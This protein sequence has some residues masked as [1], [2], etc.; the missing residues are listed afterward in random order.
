MTMSYELNHNVGG[1]NLHYITGTHYAAGH[2]SDYT[3]II[4]SST[5][6]QANKTNI[7]SLNVDQRP[8]T[9]RQYSNRKPYDNNARSLMQLQKKD[10]E[11]PITKSCNKGEQPIKFDCWCKNTEV[12]STTLVSSLSPSLLL[13][14]E[15]S[16]Y[17][18]N[19]FS[20]SSSTCDMCCRVLTLDD[21]QLYKTSDYHNLENVVFKKRQPLCDI[22]TN[23]IVGSFTLLILW[24]CCRHWRYNTTRRYVRNKKNPL[25]NIVNRNS[26]NSIRGFQCFT[27]FLSQMRFHSRH[28]K[29]CRHII[30][31]LYNINMKKKG[32]LR[33]VSKE[34]L[35]Q[36]LKSAHIILTISVL[37]MAQEVCRT[38]AS[39]ADLSA[40]TNI[41]NE[42]IGQ[43][44][45]KIHNRSD[46]HV[47]T[48]NHDRN[49]TNYK[50]NLTNN[51][52][53]GKKSDHLIKSG[54]DNSQ[55]KHS[56]SSVLVG[57]DV[58]ISDDDDNSYDGLK[59]VATK[60]KFTS[61]TG[62]SSV[63]NH[64]NNNAYLDRMDNLE[65]SLEA[66]LIK[67]AYGT[68]STTKR[69]IPDNSQ[70][71]SLTTIVTPLLT[72]LR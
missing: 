44:I 30:T 22:F 31:K 49:I 11:L 59:N 5:Y 28:R 53:N 13:Y 39:L 65:R 21:G 7:N 46:G 3:T 62:D 16:N 33:F 12:L 40:V 56:P 57:T 4:T 55:L 26:E 42:N 15:N 50:D 36:N 63:N 25:I 41:P 32:T 70:V 61:S 27:A 20:S 35:V 43:I 18:D 37:L 23:A 64:N 9:F 45:H 48:E 72:T 52:S 60:K 6:I 38:D 19:N 58:V 69:S 51:N 68:T 2:V 24:L 14:E 71:P 47:F 8:T 67:V 66:V 17:S 1:Q 29:H 10:L 54:S 34:F